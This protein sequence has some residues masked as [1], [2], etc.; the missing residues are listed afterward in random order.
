ML[1]L[2]QSI[3]VQLPFHSHTSRKT[4]RVPCCAR[5]QCVQLHTFVCIGARAHF[6]QLLRFLDGTNFFGKVLGLRGRVSAVHL[7]G[8]RWRALWQYYRDYREQ[9]LARMPPLWSPGDVARASQT[10]PAY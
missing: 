2:Q 1:R 6:F 7:Q 4:K 3:Y 9:E 8:L 10:W 5:T